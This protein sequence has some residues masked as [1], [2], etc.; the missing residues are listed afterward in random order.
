MAEVK[1]NINEKLTRGKVRFEDK[2]KICK[3][4]AQETLKK[5]KNIFLKNTLRD[6]F[7]DP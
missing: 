6:S 2:S 1:K 7:S 4:N 3:E 5:W